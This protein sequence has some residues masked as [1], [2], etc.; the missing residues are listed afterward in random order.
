M[1]KKYVYGAGIFLLAACVVFWLFHVPY[2]PQFMHR[3]LPDHVH[4]V[5]MHRDLGPRWDALGENPLAL[6]LFRSIGLKEEE[7][8]RL[9]DTPAAAW[10]GKMGRRELTL[11]YGPDAG[12]R[13]DA[14]YIAAWIG[15]RSHWYRWMLTLASPDGIRRIGKQNGDFIFL[16]EAEGD[17]PRRLSLAFV[18]GMVLAAYSA[19]PGAVRHMLDAYQ[20]VESSW[21][22]D[23]ADVS[24]RLIGGDPGAAPDRG[25]IYTGGMPPAE[26]VL[27]SF[28]ELASERIRARVKL[29]DEE[30]W[31]APETPAPAEESRFLRTGRPFL[32]GVFA[33][34]VVQSAA[35]SFMPEEALPVVEALIAASEDRSLEA[36]M[37]DGEFGGRILKFKAPGLVIAVPVDSAEEGRALMETAIDR[38][39]AQ[40]RW[41]LVP[42]QIILQELVAYVIEATDSKAYSRLDF[43]ERISYLLRPDRL[44]ISS[45]LQTLKQLVTREDASD[46]EPMWYLP[47]EP[48]PAFLGL[49]LDRAGLASRVVLAAVSFRLLLEDAE[50]TRDLRQTLRDTQGWID[51]LMPLEKG[52]IWLAIE[53]GEPVVHLSIG[54]PGPAVIREARAYEP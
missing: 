7:N 53:N 51:A 46:A 50:G 22:D 26:G 33:P 35:R 27:L 41:G 48:V 6:S 4:F 23:H 47:D 24:R 29:P 25:W 5:S 37:F 30:R 52:R 20:G 13:R 45:N 31:T 14:W 38:L 12:P 10:I 15:S 49:D 40:Y 36:A 17:D 3:A 28:D 34:A 43:D 54:P 8:G 32:H 9:V 19:D 18:E 42:R 16:A 11:A 39:N 1:K 2:R 44:Y 21:R